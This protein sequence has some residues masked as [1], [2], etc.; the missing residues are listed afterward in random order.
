MSSRILTGTLIKEE[1][2]H[3]F[4]KLNG[5]SERKLGAISAYATK[6]L[7]KKCA[8]ITDAFTHVNS[9]TVD[10]MIKVKFPEDAECS[11][12]VTKLFTDISKQ[13]GK[14]IKLRVKTRVYSFTSTY[15]HNKGQLVRGYTLLASKVLTGF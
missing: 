6:K 5:K 13:I 10:G 11:D 15:A 12:R 4:I 8:K 9:P 14:K 1:K 2:K 7:D 3:L